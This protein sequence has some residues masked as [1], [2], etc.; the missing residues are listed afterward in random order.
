MLEGAD[1]QNP[2]AAT[3]GAAGEAMLVS[4][5]LF[6]RMQA[7]LKFERTRNEALNFEITRLKRW[8]FGSSS[9]SLD[10]SEQTVLFDA[11][12]ADTALEDRAADDERKPPPAAP[13]AKRQAVRQA[14]PASLPRIDCPHELTKTHCECGQP[15]VRVG[16]EISEQ[17]DCEPARFFVLRHIRG[18]YACACCQTIQAEPMPAQMIDKGI[19]APG[20]LAQVVVAKHDDHLPLYRQTEV[21]A[22]SGVHIPRSSM[23][24]WIGTCGV[25]LAPLVEALKDFILSHSVI[26]ADETPVSLLAPGRGKTKKAYMWVY[27][28]TNFVARR[29]VLFDFCNSRSGEH[30]RRVLEG[31]CQTLVS[32]DFSGYHALHAGGVTA[33]F[34]VAHARRKLFEAHKFN[35]SEIAAGAIARIAKLYEIER[36]AKDLQPDERLRMR[37]QLSRP[38]AD[39]LHEWLRTQRQAL[40]KADVTARA[41]DYSLSNWSALTRFLDDGNVPID[42]NAAENSVRPLCVGR[43]NWLFVGSQQAGERAAAVLSL[44]ESAKLNGHDPWAYLKDVFER[45]PTLKQRDLD[46]LLPHNWRPAGNTATPT[47]KPVEVA[48]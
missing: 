24:Q 18:K 3:R 31:F 32:D 28:T 20:L 14:L 45:L 23:A 17:L 19:P 12:V 10:S 47:A 7:E 6:E 33:A 41:I 36:E 4:R 5:E 46:Q 39:A 44:I 35:G 48:A 27:R 29:A 13:R 43:K 26:H 15:L 16:E 11:I 1:A 38:I 25:R 9:E 8:R 42:N 37:Q 40:A 21:Y 2:D 34:C 30:P 22:R